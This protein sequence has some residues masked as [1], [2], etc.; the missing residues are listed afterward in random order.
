[1]EHVRKLKCTIDLNDAREVAYWT[2]RL[3]ITTHQLQRLVT[4]LKLPTPVKP[5]DALCPAASNP[6]SPEANCLFAAERNAALMG[7]TI[8]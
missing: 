7:I 8:G 4:V 3:H 6:S 1:M 5:R 2:Q